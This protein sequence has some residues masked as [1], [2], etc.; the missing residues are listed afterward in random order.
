MYIATCIH[1]KFFTYLMNE[2]ERKNNI[3][4]LRIACDGPG[5]YVSKQHNNRFFIDVIQI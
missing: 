2:K 3:F 5:G 1:N 4:F